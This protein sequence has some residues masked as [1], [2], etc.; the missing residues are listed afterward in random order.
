MSAAATEK[1]VLKPEQATAAQTLDSHVS[2]TAGPG[3]GKTMVLVERYLHIL[4]EHPHL[5]IDQIVA[6]TFTNRAANE[7]RERLREKLDEL[8]Q[9]S[10][11]A[12]RQRWMNYKRTL[13]GGIITTIHGF[14]SR[15]LREFP[16][17]ARVDPQ[18]ILLDEHQ[19]AILLE[20]TVEETLTESINSGHEAVSRLTAGL[21]RGKLVAALVELYRTIRG[22]GLSSQLLAEQA[23][24]SHA[25]WEHYRA[26][27][28]EVD[29]NMGELISTGRLPLKAEAKRSKARRNWPRLRQLLLDPQLPLADY[30]RE[31]SEFREAARPSA[32]G[33]LSAVVKKLDDLFWG[34]K[35]EKPFG[36]VPGLRF[37]LVAKEYACEALK[38]L[39]N[40]D[41]RLEE[42]KR[43]LAALDFD[44]LQ[45][46]ALKLLEQPEV[47]LRASRRY[48]FFLVDEFQDTNPL[49]RDLMDRLALKNRKDAN[50][51]IVGDP[52]QS[53]YGFRG[54]DV[55]VFRE[56]TEALIKAA[57]AELPLRANFRSQPQLISFFNLLF[58]QLFQPGK[59]IHPD[60]L[61]ALGYVKHDPS[62]AER[63][64]VDEGPLVELMIDTGGDD[65]GSPARQSG[66]PGRAAGSPR[67]G[68][69]AA[70]RRWGGLGQPAW[71]AGSRLACHTRWG[72]VDANAKSQQTTRERDAHQLA[73]RILSLVN[74]ESARAGSA[75]A[76]SAA[77]GS[78]GDVA[79]LFR[80][81]TDVPVYESVFRRANI[82]Y[83]TVLGKGFYEREEI[84]DLMQLL[85]FLDNGTDELALAAVLRS[86]LCGISDN[87]LLALRLAPRLG[88]TETGETPQPPQARRRPRKLFHALKHQSEIDFL[89]N[90]ERDALERAEKLLH[91]LI[92]K[93]NR[94]PVGD[95]LRFAVS[96]SEYA[97]V[98]AANFDGAQRLA[99]VEKLFTLAER[100]ERSGAHL[101]RDFV[102]Y[103]HDFEAIGSRESEGQLD[104][105][106]NAVTLMT[107]HQAKGLEFP[108][109]I[110][111]DL[112][113]ISGPKDNWF[114][115]DRHLGL[116]LK[117]PDG[118]GEQVAGGTFQR[119]SDRAKRREQFES[120]RLL[121]VAATRA[122]DRLILSAATDELSKLDKG[123]ECWLKWIWQA[124]ELQNARRSGIVDLG[125]ETQLQLTLNLS[126]EPVRVPEAAK[127][128]ASENGSANAINFN[129]PPAELFPL[130]HPVE[131]G[132]DGAVHR[133]SVT[134]LINYQRCPR[135]Y[136]FDR[137]LHVPSA[138]ELAVWNNAE[139]PEPP[140]N[141]TATLK[142]AVIHRFCETY[143]QGDVPEERLR[144]SFDD[145]IRSR[146]AQLTDRLDDIN[147]NEALK[148]LWP[149]AQN[150]LS[151]E[152]FQRIERASKMAGD[153]PIGF[154][155]KQA[156]LWSELAFRLRRPLG[157][158]TG[159]IDKLLISPSNDGQAFEIEIIDFKTNHIRSHRSTPA[160][161]FTSPLGTRASR[162]QSRE[163]ATQSDAK[164]Q[165]RAGQAPQRGDPARKRSQY[166]VATQ[167][168]LDF[169]EPVS[170]TESKSFGAVEASTTLAQ[171]ADNASPSR[172]DQI[173]LA[174][175][176]YQLQMQAY[177]LAVRELAPNFVSSGSEIKVTL[178]FLHPNLEFHLSEDLLARDICARAIDDAILA[179]I[180]ST[181]P[182]Q[183]PVRPATHCR[184]CNFLELCPAGRNWLSI[185]ASERL[186]YGHSKVV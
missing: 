97:T 63:E 4:K 156:G 26:A 101:I 132:R 143:S 134:Q 72:A 154:P 96:R 183:F 177:A 28:A 45:I 136:Y 54:A 50:L 131:V 124:L 53:I 10:P 66:V 99:N 144:Q 179:I 186:T 180:S 171:H 142:G 169:S 104:E 139:A 21:G 128:K 44:D 120:L 93:R 122:K 5:N 55:D 57:G 160:R 110:I 65:A 114:L 117:V 102:K 67:P 20:A 23:A 126:D 150:Y 151:S 6:L 39:T 133:F 105:A 159:T 76:E 18:F 170:E 15:L 162:P 153:S 25:T 140:A 95:L 7:M 32:Q 38:L 141:L 64:R 185:T 49:Q 157:I 100:F 174:A 123:H 58:E 89:A 22:Q 12:E 75:A 71:G 130:L 16:V 42:T 47:L 164:I 1:R 80:A 181:T 61:R 112:Q 85:R 59:E 87:S 155:D 2:V 9:T 103:V 37:D 88:E 51:F 81:M 175:S 158:L 74:P 17:E 84:T 8:L 48:K 90:E 77:A 119:F 167:F 98:V 173:R 146:Q 147:A 135:Q 106:A 108:V 145:V 70:Q 163:A 138:D 92:E 115:L 118:R 62:K 41:S 46:R 172:D 40:I 86:P 121:Y 14:C 82:P 79:L 111:P 178:H 56:M 165:I 3:A 125:P 127:L 11:P 43:Q 60:D 27:F 13:D 107:I 91:S 78:F 35:R 168:L 68:S 83:Q 148:E 152:V 73:R 137:I 34:E 36:Q 129:Q 113:R 33:S 24:R 30:C 69:P 184:M 31:I 29:R 94:Y 176:D 182:E 116:T 166:S 19:S 161:A 149:L 52:K 109:V